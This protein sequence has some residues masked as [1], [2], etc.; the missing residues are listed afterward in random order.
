MVNKS[1][2]QWNCRGLHANREE[3]DML[4]HRYNSN[5]ICLQ[6]TLIKDKPTYKGFTSYYKRGTID[7]LGRCH[8]GVA[9]LVHNSVP[10]S[11][12]QLKT[13][14]LQPESLWVCCNQSHSGYYLYSLLNLYTTCRS[15]F[16]RPFR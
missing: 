15:N 4:V 11:E 2:L 6:E 16:Y 14:L 8:G 13:T 9:I 3:L 5:I 7:A 12:V 10:Q 1:I